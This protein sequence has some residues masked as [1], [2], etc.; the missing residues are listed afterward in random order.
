M[1]APWSGWPPQ[2]STDSA[3]ASVWDARV[4]GAGLAPQSDDFTEDTIASGKWAIWDFG[5]NITASIDTTAR[6]MILEGATGG[7]VE[8][9][10]AYQPKPS[11]V[12]SFAAKIGFGNGTM[13]TGGAQPFVGVAV[14]ENALNAASSFIA[15]E[16]ER[17]SNSDNWPMRCRDVTTWN[18]ASGFDTRNMYDQ[19]SERWLRGRVSINPGVN[20]RLEGDWSTDGDRWNEWRAQVG[21]NGR[22]RVVANALHFGIVFLNMQAVACQA[23]VEYFR[24]WDGV[25]TPATIPRNGG[26][27]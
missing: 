1:S 25:N 14:F 24:V 2:A 19:P 15:L 12:F 20:Y 11:N 5:G 16:M 9:S 17:D 13:G 10:G 23:S 7:A 22:A 18:G 8:W 6:A 3:A 21:P 27:L 4:A 26:Y